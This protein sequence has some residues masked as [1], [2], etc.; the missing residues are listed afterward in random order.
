MIFTDDKLIEFGKVVL[1]HLYEFMDSHEDEDPVDSAMMNKKAAA[2][3][4]A[5]IFE[6]LGYF[7][8]D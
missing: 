2:E 1:E 5:N 8:E 3:T 6:E 4:L 7:M